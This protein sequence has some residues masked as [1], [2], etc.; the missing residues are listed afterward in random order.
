MHRFFPHHIAPMVYLNLPFSMYFEHKCYSLF[1]SLI[2]SYF[3]L[4][5]VSSLRLIN[6]CAFMSLFYQLLGTPNI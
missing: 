5:G 6:A 2:L 3:L 1:N 4:Y